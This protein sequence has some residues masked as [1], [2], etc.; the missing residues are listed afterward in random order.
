MYENASLKFAD[1][2]VCMIQEYCS[3]LKS[4]ENHP[5]KKICFTTKNYTVVSIMGVG[6]SGLT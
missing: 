2:K 4:L 5:Y 1:Q 6:L 3:G